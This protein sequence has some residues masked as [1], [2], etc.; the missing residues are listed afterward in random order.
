MKFN[1][2]TFI[3]PIN[4]DTTLRLRDSDNNIVFYIKV[5]DCTVAVSENALLVKQ[6]SESN[7][8]VLPFDNRRSAIEAQKL[9]REALI[10]LKNNQESAATKTYHFHEQFTPSNNWIIYH[11]LGKYTHVTIFDDN[12][13][14][15]IGTVQK[16]STNSLRI[17]FNENITGKA[18]IS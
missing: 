11:G 14:A 13:Y 8:V 18:M 3:V 5:P 17:L 1:T 16:L 15:I 7:T 9:L 2:D 6:Q 10:F 4:S 12:N